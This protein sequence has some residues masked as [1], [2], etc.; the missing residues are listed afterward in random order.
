MRLRWVGDSRDY[1]KW[2]CVYENSEGRLVFYV[3]MLRSDV[4]AVCKH[5]EVQRHF[6]KRKSLDQFHDLFPD[7]FE[8]FVFPRS[9][10]S[11]KIASEYFSSVVIR[12]RELQRK[13]RVL[14]FLDPDTGVEP[15]SGASD[16]HVRGNDLR[17]VWT[18]LRPG[19][20]MIVY[21][22][23][24]RS[25]GWKDAL[26]MRASEFLK[27]EPVQVPNPYFTGNLAKDV[28]F[29]VLEKPES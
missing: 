16:E 25:A 21:Q 19:D 12:L 11:T 22:H 6:D 18:A 4:D 28:C 20:K 10:Y 9:E 14:V 23:A 2:D 17:T 1:V 3:P 7:R 26:R 8:V 27:I 13:G 24:S 5:A 29:L 15:T